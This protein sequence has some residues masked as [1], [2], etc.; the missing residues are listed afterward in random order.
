LN[1]LIKRGGLGEKLLNLHVL[2]ISSDMLRIFFLY[3][4]AR[5][6]RKKGMLRLF[7]MIFFSLQPK[8]G[9]KCPSYRLLLISTKKIN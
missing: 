2:T 3:S 4:Q 9:C 1:A 8:Q 5:M 7:W 6:H